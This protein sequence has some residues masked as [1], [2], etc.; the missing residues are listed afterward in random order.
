MN[1]EQITKGDFPF[2]ED[3]YDRAS[4]DA[5]L[6]AVAAHTGALEARIKALEVEREALRRRSGESSAAVPNAAAAEPS[7][8]APAGESPD[9]APSGDADEVSARLVAT[10]LA[11]EG[12][13]REEI[14]AKLESGYELDDVDAVVDDVLERLG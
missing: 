2:A 10:R 5:H 9:G 8:E 6:E 13:G 7:N 14:R 12:T 3:G 1:R 11:L 4:V